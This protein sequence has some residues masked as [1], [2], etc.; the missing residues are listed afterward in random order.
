MKISQVSLLILI[1][2]VTSF[3]GVDT[4][5]TAG[6]KLVWSDE[7]NGAANSAPDPTKWTY[8]LGNNGGW[9]NNEQENYTSST[10][11]S[12]QDGQGH[13]V[14]QVL[15]NSGSYTSA[16]L[17][18]EGLYSLA[19]GRVVAR[20]KIPYAQ[21]IWPAFWMLGNNITTVGWPACGETDI[22]ENFGVQNNDAS[23]NHGTLHG[24]GYQGAGLSAT[25]ELPNGEQFAEDFHL[26]QIDW[27]P[28]SVK[29]YVDGN[30]YSTV[31]PASM[32]PGGTWPFDNNPM[33]FI[34]NVAVGSSAT[35]APVGPPTGT[36]FPQ[37]MLVDYVRVYQQ[38]PL[39]ISTTPN[40]APWG[41]VNAASSGGV[42]APGSLVSVYG[43]NLADATYNSLFDTTAGQFAT[44]TT[45]GVTA[46]VN[47]VPAPL[48]Y[49]SPTQINLQ[50]PWETP[51]DPTAV[52]TVTVNTVSGSSYGEPLTLGPAAPAAFIDYSNNTALL[53]C[54]GSPITGGSICTIYGNGFGP[55]NAAAS[56][57]VPAPATSL[58][59]IEVPGSPAS[60]QL[61]VGGQTATVTYCGSAPFLVIDQLNF[62]YPTGIPANSGP[63]T[64]SL[65]IDG[66]TGWFQLPGPTQ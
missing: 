20:I 6:W 42:V 49:V 57:G 9:G 8:D 55:K 11:N 5:P 38:V 4:T 15:N 56:D 45:S 27:E 19:Y 62:V 32:P 47:G 53:N 7:F 46:T 28:D 50:I 36:S 23:S 61:T 24:P 17:K 2:S 41:V 34:L 12:Y 65:D 29:F 3:G 64:A 33:F 48:I 37:Q 44:S 16:R 26:F 14:I 59:D 39:S 30:L 66:Q 63:Q 21:G 54:N 13:L 18:T 10:Q 52:Q 1:S 31:T 25:Y 43:I 40:I 60:C 35:P 22:M 51:T 58:T